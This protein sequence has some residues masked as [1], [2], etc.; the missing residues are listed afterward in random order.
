[1]TYRVV[2]L[3]DG[4]IVHVGPDRRGLLHGDFGF[5]WTSAALVGMGEGVGQ[6]ENLLGVAMMIGAGVGGLTGA[7]IAW[8]SVKTLEFLYKKIKNSD[9]LTGEAL[10]KA[11][12]K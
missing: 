2:R 9:T 3:R 4:R 5:D 6:T 11:N 7:G 8:F 12:I 1:M 10:R